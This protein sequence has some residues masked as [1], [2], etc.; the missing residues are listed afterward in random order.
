[1]IWYDQISLFGKKILISRINFLIYVDSFDNFDTD[2]IRWLADKINW[3]VGK[4]LSK[5]WALFS[6]LEP[7][8]LREYA[9]K[10]M[11]GVAQ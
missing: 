1:M 10:N 7:S 5:I 9:K 11:R 8:R 2:L 6:F 4:N 3:Y